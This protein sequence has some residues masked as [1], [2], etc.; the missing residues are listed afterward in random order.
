MGAEEEVIKTLR[1]ILS[2]PGLSPENRKGAI[3]KLSANLVFV[4]EV[5]FT[6]SDRSPVNRSTTSASSWTLYPT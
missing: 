6:C 2:L 1:T 3:S 5:A 4:T